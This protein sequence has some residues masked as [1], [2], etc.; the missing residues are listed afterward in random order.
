MIKTA[1][2]SPKQIALL[3]VAK[4]ELSLD[5]GNY[6]AVLSLY[7]GAESAKDVTQAGFTR[8]MNYLVRIGFNA[9]SFSPQ[10]RRERDAGALIGPWQTKKIE[11]FYVALG[12]LTADRQ[13]KL[14][15]RVIKKAWP[16]TRS[17]ANKMIECLKAMA[18]RAAP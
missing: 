4:R 14:C 8:L 5:E 6:R 18:K 13:Q 15:K 17:D 2:I 12:I 9:P 7:G 16:Q 3:H 10:P 11:E 1:K